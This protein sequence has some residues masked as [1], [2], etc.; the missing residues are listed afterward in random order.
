MVNFSSGSSLFVSERFVVHFPLKTSD[1]QLLDT[2]IPIGT[3]GFSAVSASKKHAEVQS[4][5]LVPPEPQ[6][7]QGGVLGP[8][9]NGYFMGI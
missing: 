8:E 2:Q 1:S 5:W 3:T 7:V 6:K 9:A 4:R